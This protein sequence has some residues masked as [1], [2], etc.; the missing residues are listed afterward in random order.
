MCRRWMSRLPRWPSGPPLAPA[1]RSD[2]VSV[3]HRAERVPLTCHLRA[4]RGP[5]GVTGWPG[6]RHRP[7]NSILTPDAL[8]QGCCPGAHGRVATARPM[9]A[10]SRTTD[11]CG[12]GMGC[13]PTPRPPTCWSQNGWS[14]KK[15]TTTVAPRP[16]TRCGWCQHRRDGRPRPYEETASRAG[17]GRPPGPRRRGQRWPAGRPSPATASPGSR[18]GRSAATVSW[19]SATASRS[20]MLPKPT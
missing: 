11:S 8:A 13:G 5:I 3:P 6:R 4:A 14:V 10:A 2:A 1:L 7:R 18:P 12:R 9:A 20:V 16:T 17:P 15:G 19:A